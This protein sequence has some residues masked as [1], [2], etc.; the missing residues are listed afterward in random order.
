MA[1]PATGASQ[2][3]RD[4]N[5]WSSLFQL[6]SSPVPVFFQ[7]WQLNLKTLGKMVSDTLDHR[8]G[9][10]VV[11]NGGSLRHRAKGL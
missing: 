10:L 1:Q 11:S 2:I 7:F 5:Q 4:H 8:A 6:K 3:D 9:T